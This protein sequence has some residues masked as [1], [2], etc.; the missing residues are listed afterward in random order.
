VNLPDTDQVGHLTGGSTTNPTAVARTMAAADDQIGRLLDAY[1][2]AGLAD[3][4]LWVVT[5]DHGMT[6]N[7]V[8]VNPR[9][10]ERTLGRGEHG[11]LAGDTVHYWMKKQSDAAAAAALLDRQSAPGVFGTYFKADLGNG[12]FAY[13]PTPL[14][15]ARLSN[16]QAAALDYLFGTFAGPESPDLTVVLGENVHFHTAPVNTIG[17]HSEPTWLLQ[18]IP[19]IF[20]GPGVPS[21]R[22]SRYPARLVDVAPTVLALLGLPATGMDGATLHDALVATT[23][24][25]SVQQ[26][27]SP[28]AARLLSYQDALVGLSA[29]G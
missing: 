2:R 21:G 6:P 28:Q 26:L 1:A 27:S 25:E 18:R 9:F 13:Q 11:W 24:E 23:P 10:I 12:R 16:G 5:S 17:A 19:L 15:Q 14:A 8:N 29:P 22:V 3:S 20:S 7:S 4:T